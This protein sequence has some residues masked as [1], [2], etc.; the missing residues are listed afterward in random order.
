MRRKSTRRVKI[1]VR[2]LPTLLVATSIF[3][4]TEA[5]ATALTGGHE[6]T[7]E[8]SAIYEV[9]VYNADGALGWA[10]AR[11][12]RLDSGEAWLQVRISTSPG[13]WTEYND[14]LDASEY[15]ITSGWTSWIVADVPGLGSVYLKLVAD[16]G[17]VPYNWGQSAFTGTTTELVAR[18][19][20]SLAIRDHAQY[21]SHLGP[22]YTTGGGGSSVT[23]RNMNVIWTDL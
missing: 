3:A 4:M 14:T 1:I 10:S 21:G 11:A 15:W 22:W 8:F 7:A 19:L 12:F 20:N 2:C 16:G 6:E 18:D 17:F 23:S 13:S 5:P 9:D